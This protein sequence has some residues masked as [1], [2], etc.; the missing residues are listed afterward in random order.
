MKRRINRRPKFSRDVVA[1]GQYLAQDSFVVASRFLDQVDATVEFLAALPGIGHPWETDAP[2][3]QGLRWYPVKRFRRHLI[4]YRDTG[5]ELEL[6]RLL[7]SSQNL[8][9]AIS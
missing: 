5:N 8:V 4:F 9:A 7:H 6:L 3:N 1:H 2:E